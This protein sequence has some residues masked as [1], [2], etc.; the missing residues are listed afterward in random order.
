MCPYSILS[1]GIEDYALLFQRPT[2]RHIEEDNKK[3]I[4]SADRDVLSLVAITIANCCR[5]VN[6][7]LI[8]FT[9]EEKVVVDNYSIR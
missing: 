2:S 1:Q 4:T 7:N 3:I 6:I 9:E 8:F 5:F